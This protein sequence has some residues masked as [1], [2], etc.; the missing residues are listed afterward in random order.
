MKTCLAILAHEG[1]EET[2]SDFM[3]RWRALGV[4][5]WGCYPEKDLPAD[6]WWDE[7]IF[8]GKSAHAGH[9][10]FKRFCETCDILAD[11]DFDLFVIAEYDTANLGEDLPTWS[12]DSLSSYLVDI[13]ES[14]MCML[15]PWVMTKH[16]LG[17]FIEAMQ[18]ELSK[19]P[20]C[21]ESKGLLD[22]WIGI[23]CE[24]HDIPFAMCDN[25]LSYPWH[26][27]AHDRIKR[28]GYQWVHGWKHAADFKDLWK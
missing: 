7:M 4:P 3:P 16:T 27:G 12:P 28:M 1:S 10:V 18:I 25:S 13:G 21:L 5:V 23:V 19:D 26:V 20:E 17:Y 11:E 24:R 8:T 9:E 6:D 14:F 22:R 2:V 15:S